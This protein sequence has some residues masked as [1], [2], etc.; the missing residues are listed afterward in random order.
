VAADANLA[1]EMYPDQSL[2]PANSV[3]SVVKR[4]NGCLLRADQIAHSEGKDD[5]DYLAPIV[6]DAE[7]GFGGVLNAFEIMKS[8]IEAGAAGVHFE[9]QLASAKKC[10]HMGGNPGA[11]AEAE[12]ALG[13]ATG[14]G[15]PGRADAAAR[16]H[17]RGGREPHTS[18]IDD[19]TSPHHGERT[20]EGFFRVRRL[21]PGRLARHRLRGLCRHVCARRARRTGFRQAL[22]RGDP[23]GPPDKMLAYN[24]SPR[25]TG[26]RTSTTPD[27]ALPARVGAMG[28]KFHINTTPVPRATADVDLAYGYARENI[29]VREAAAG[30]VR[31]AERGFTA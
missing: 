5:I 21:R 31:A 25:S 8:M 1:G 9:D 14:R 20:S 29:I 4:I 27:R 3:P 10:G 30:G 12:T 2:Y 6:A 28:Y 24:C 17:R 19:S 23:Q 11:H 7:A 15:P 18:D 16:A 26:R 22:R 13:R